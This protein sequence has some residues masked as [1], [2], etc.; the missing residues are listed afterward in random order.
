LAVRH[1][2]QFELCPQG[3]SLDVKQAARELGVRYVLEGS[4]RKAGNRVRIAGQLIDSATGAHI[5]AERFDGTVDDIFEFQDLVASGVVGAI[6]PQL[7]VVEA[8]RAVRKPTDSLDAYDL[9]WRAQAQAFKRTSEGLVESIR[10]ARLALDLDPS[11]GPAMSRLALSRGMQRHRNWIPPAGPEVEEGIA[12]ARRA[13]AA[14]GHDPWVLDFAGLALA[15]LAGD[16]DAALSALDRAIVLNPNFAIAFGHRALVL[17]YLNRPE[18]AIRSGRQAMRLSPLD[19]VMFAFY[20][21]LALA[22]LAAGRYEAGL[23]WA[24]QALREN[25]GMPAFRLKLSLCGHLGRVDDARACLSPRASFNASQ[26]SRGSCAHCRRAPPRNSPLVSLTGCARLASRRDDIVYARP[27]MIDGHCSRLRLQIISHASSRLRRILLKKS[28]QRELAP[29]LGNNDS[30]QPASLNHYCAREAD[31]D[32]ILLMNFTS[33]LFQQY[34]R[35]LDL[36]VLVL[37][38][39]WPALSS[40][41]LAAVPIMRWDGRSAFPTVEKAPC[42]RVPSTLYPSRGLRALPHAAVRS[43]GWR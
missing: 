18:E 36:L 8:E 9:Y 33:R 41:M 19:P 26:R 16:T 21:A 28:L 37:S 12:M 3:K 5:W 22:E 32:I 2:A 39:L 1:R 23:S 27:A 17:A 6:E 29:E 30:N 25:S 10:L 40:A 38:I 31:R 24:E 13:I 34:R 15:Q 14:A 4:V 42:R 7:R 43:E 20:Q 35:Y 11:Y